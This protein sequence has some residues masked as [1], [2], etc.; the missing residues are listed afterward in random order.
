MT[1]TV[2]LFKDTYMSEHRVWFSAGPFS[3]DYN[4]R[5]VMNGVIYRTI[6]EYLAEQAQALKDPPAFGDTT[7]DHSKK[8]AAVFWDLRLYDIYKYAV[9]EKVMQNV[10]TK[11]MLIETGSRRIAFADLHEESMYMALRRP[12]PIPDAPHGTF[13]ATY[14]LGPILMDVRARIIADIT[15]DSPS[16]EEL[17]EEREERDK[18]RKL[19]REKAAAAAAAA[20][21]ADTAG[22]SEA[23]ADTAGG[24]EATADT[25]G[26]SEVTVGE[27]SEATAD[28][29]GGSEVT[30]GEGSE[31]TADTVEGSDAT[32]DTA[33]EG[34]SQAA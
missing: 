15:K 5:F 29:D 31:V 8:P 25:D 7:V 19:K 11:R 22:G 12:A 10:E 28:T 3:S 16:L 18:R 20:A 2:R 33:V 13:S 26:G 4:N 34:S 23:T 17:M 24:S 9:F 6:S 27:G 32:V 21:T 1:A 14:C 30:V